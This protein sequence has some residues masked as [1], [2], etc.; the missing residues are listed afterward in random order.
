MITEHQAHQPGVFMITILICPDLM[1]PLKDETAGYVEVQKPSYPAALSRHHPLH[2]N[3]GD[4][5]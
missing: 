5:P 4:P 3:L 1:R 2:A